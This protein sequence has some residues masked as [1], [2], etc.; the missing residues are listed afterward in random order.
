MRYIPVI[1]I[2]ISLLL[3][4]IIWHIA[5]SFRTSTDG[6]L[7]AVDSSARIEIAE[8]QAEIAELRYLIEDLQSQL[9]AIR[10]QPMRR[11]EAPVV[12]PEADGQTG[13]DT[14]A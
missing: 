10:S 2:S 7:P 3:T 1:I 8:M 14:S 9:A 13:I 4:P 12:T 6:G 11:H 5:A